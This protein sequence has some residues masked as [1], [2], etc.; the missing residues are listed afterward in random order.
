MSTALYSL[1]IQYACLGGAA[2]GILIY[3]VG[4]GVAW[5]ILSFWAQRWHAVVITG[6]A[7]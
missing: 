1:M 4:L 7:P 6:V 2:S 3:L 5:A